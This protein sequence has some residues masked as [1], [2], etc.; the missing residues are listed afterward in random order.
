MR[1]DI[2]FAAL[3]GWTS[4]T[5][6]F[7]DQASIDVPDR[8]KEFA[9][10]HK[11]AKPSPQLQTQLQEMIDKLNSAEFQANQADMNK[12]VSQLINGDPTAVVTEDQ[13]TPA[14][15]N[16]S[17]DRAILFIS[18]TIPLDVL[19][20]Y[21]RDLAKING[22]MVL[23]GMK[24]GIQK[25]QPTIAFIGDIVKID[26]DCR[27]PAC[28]IRRLDVIVDPVLFRENRIEAVPALIFVPNMQMI[29]YCERGTEANR[30]DA[31]DVVYGDASLPGML[32]ALNRIRRDRRLEFYIDLLEGVRRGNT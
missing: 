11:E 1:I 6:G 16:N 12:R 8:Y 4:A 17:V 25:L 3:I 31:I 2:I 23:R 26:P 24:G 19:R 29:S 13:S 10:D 7:A 30:I 5:L 22:V 32:K 20:R 21:A 9:R 18:E 14:A 27:G 28:K 15:T